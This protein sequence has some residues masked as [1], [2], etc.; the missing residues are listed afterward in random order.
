MDLR[1]ENGMFRA[2]D[3]FSIRKY[4]F[5]LLI[6]PMILAGVSGSKAFTQADPQSA[7]CAKY[8]PVKLQEYPG[9]MQNLVTWVA[10]EQGFMKKHCLAPQIVPIPS[11]PA[12][13]AASIQGGVDFVLTAPE[14]AYIPVSK[15]LDVKIVAGINDTIHYALVVSKTI[16]DQ[17]RGD[18]FETIMKALVGKR[19]GVNALG[20]TTDQFGRVNFVAAGL[21]PAD[22][23]WIAYGPLAAAIAGLKNGSLD[24]AEFFSD[25]MDIAVAATG[26]MIVVDLRDPKAKTTPEVAALRGASLEWAVPTAFIEANPDLVKRVVMASNEAV[27]WI[28]DPKNFDTIIDIVR[29]KAPSPEGIENPQALLTE[30][31]KRYIPQVSEKLNLKSLK[32]WNARA[33]A[34]G[35]IPAPADIDKIIWQGAQANVVP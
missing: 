20:S 6:L 21:N 25:G 29:V 16:A 3:I 12:A 17:H 23:N 5:P 2:N 35:R 19:I 15:G 32:A 27:A 10:T 30:R 9:L 4:Q 33:V 1:R 22:A 26:G 28:K 13:F 31:V 11:A 14:T 34:E 8:E 24:A 18:G 7:A